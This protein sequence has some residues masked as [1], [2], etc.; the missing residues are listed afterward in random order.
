MS[1]WYIGTRNNKYYVCRDI[2]NEVEYLL[3]DGNITKIDEE[4][5]MFDTIQ[6]AQEAV[7]KKNSLSLVKPK[8]IIVRSFVLSDF[9]EKVS[10]YLERGFTVVEGTFNVSI[11]YD[12]RYKLHFVVLNIP[13]EN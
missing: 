12:S 4:A 1:A 13:G 11:T 6:E 8:Q 9:M 10:E 3:F 7:R 5:F 2:D